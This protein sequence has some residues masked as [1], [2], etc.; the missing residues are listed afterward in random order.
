[1]DDIKQKI[2]ITVDEK[3]TAETTKKVGQLNESISQT[4]SENKKSE[5]EIGRAH[6]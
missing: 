1:M 2:I 3:G 4:T 5:E 6:V